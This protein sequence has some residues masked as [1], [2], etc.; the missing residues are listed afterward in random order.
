MKV[1]RENRYFPGD[2]GY[3]CLHGVN[4]DIEIVTLV[5]I[6]GTR[7][8]FES[9]LVTYGITWIVRTA[10]REV[11]VSFLFVLVGKETAVVGNIAACIFIFSVICK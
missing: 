1:C 6:A 10:E 7:V 11:C 8:P 2:I 9:V 4:R 3:V 5:I